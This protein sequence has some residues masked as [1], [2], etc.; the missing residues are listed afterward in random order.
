MGNAVA[1][2]PGGSGNVTDSHKVWQVEL[3][4]NA[5]G[6][7]IVK[8]GH[9]YILT[10][11]GF[12][13]CVSLK[14]GGIVWEERVRGKGPKNESWST[15]VLV[16]D[17]LYAVN[18]SGD[19]IMMKAA[20]KFEMIGIN[21]IGNELTNSLLAVSDGEIFLR[22]HENLWCFGTLKQTASR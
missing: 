4:K 12:A 13:Q 5:L 11:E 2:K 10:S 3:K 1:V 22:T 18:Q 19:V 21:S 6:T 7:P 14:D 15:M 20:T 8:D 9:I 17:T 16:G